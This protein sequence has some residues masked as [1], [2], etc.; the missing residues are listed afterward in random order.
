MATI[1]AQ[2]KTITAMTA[3]G[4]P[5]PVIDVTQ[6]AFAVDDSAE[7]V[8]ALRDAFVN[9]ERRRRRLPR[10]VMGLLM[11]LAARRSLLLRALLRP[12]AGFLG[13][14][15]TYV[16]KLGADNLVPPFGDRVDKQ[17]ADSPPVRSMRVRLQQLARL[18]ADGLTP[19]LAGRPGLPLHLISIGGGT[20]IDILNAL[21]VLRGAAP[22]A[23]ARPVSI[24][25]LDLDGRAPLFGANALAALRAGD[26]PLTG[27][28]IRLV[29]TRYSWDDT[30]PL[31]RLLGEIQAA[32]AIIAA[33]S[34]GALFEYGSDDAVIGNLRVLHNHAVRAVTGSVT[35]AD[36]LTLAMIANSRFKLMPRGIDTFSS[37]AARAGF[38]VAKVAPA[39]MSDQV[40]LRPT[41][42]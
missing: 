14:L 1:P 9:S 27:L 29:H 31:D 17:V 3:D 34:E 20:A 33:S 6:P 13:G 19:E 42:G 8:A 28:D 5:L 23:L 41:R 2:R 16:L 32:P 10:F 24:H 39:L 11:R 35:R 36:E 40:L 38:A 21:I 22:E 37:L 7:A 18:L 30:A 12:N 15:S 25:V 4:Y 26:G